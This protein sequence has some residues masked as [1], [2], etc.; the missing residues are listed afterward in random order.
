MQVPGSKLQ[1]EKRNYRKRFWIEVGDWHHRAMI[2]EQNGY[3]VIYSIMHIHNVRIVAQEV[4][5]EELYKIYVK[6]GGVVE[7]TNKGQLKEPR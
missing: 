6:K 1:I 4:Y 3:V 5:H 2:D 7:D